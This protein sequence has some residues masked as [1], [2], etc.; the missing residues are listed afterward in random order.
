MICLSETWLKDDEPKSELHI[1]GYIQH[2][3]S[4]GGEGGKGLA[5]FYKPEKFRASGDVKQRDLQIT[6]LSS[7]DV[8]MILVY[9]NASCKNTFQY[10]YQMIVHGKT[11]TICGD[12]TVCFFKKKS[13]TLIQSL[14]KLGFEQRVTEATHFQ[15]GL[16]DHT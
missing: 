4:Y 11:T 10:I 8:D 15:E 7:I 3:N 5:V 13:N 14:L 1:H 6:R 12:F 9:R 16:I 2:L